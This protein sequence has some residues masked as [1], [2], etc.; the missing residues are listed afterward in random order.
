MTDTVEGEEQSESSEGKR[1]QLKQST[2][3]HSSARSD[4]TGWIDTVPLLGV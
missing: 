1:G 2:R 3:A 4:Y